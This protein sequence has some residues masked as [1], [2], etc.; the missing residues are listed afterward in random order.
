M[1][2]ENTI[3]FSDFARRAKEKI[4]EKKKRRT[5][6]L[7]VEEADV[8]ITVRGI[9]E[10]ELAECTEFSD[11]SLITDKYMIYLACDD[12]HEPASQLVSDGAI[13][14]HYEICDMFTLADRREIAQQIMRL[15]GMYAE[16]TVK[17]VDEVE[18][19]KN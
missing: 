3:I 12:L 8:N 2:Q 10:Q 16:S 18:E 17:P 13:K 1:S 15:S 5:K 4:E 6:T 14:H 19:V 11:D 9:S 7:Y